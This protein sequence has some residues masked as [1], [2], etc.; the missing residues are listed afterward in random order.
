MSTLWICKYHD[1]CDGKW[2][3][4]QDNINTCRYKYTIDSS[5]VYRRT[6]G[7][8]YRI[9]CHRPDISQSRYGDSVAVRWKGGKK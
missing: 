1:K 2:K 5:C 3:D 6:S 8:W 4:Y 7:N 9:P